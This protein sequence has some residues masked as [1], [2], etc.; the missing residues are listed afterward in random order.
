[1]GRRA[2]G[3]ALLTGLDRSSRSRGDELRRHLI[4]RGV[5]V[6][7]LALR[8]LAAER[9]RGHG[10]RRDRLSYLV[11]AL[12]PRTVESHRCAARL[13]GRTTLTVAVSTHRLNMLTSATKAPVEVDDGDRPATRVR[14][15]A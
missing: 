3:V 9:H 1:M 5:Q 6:S 7:D 2:G 11:K 10:T 12:G 4:E 13:G 8:P 15:C 14:S